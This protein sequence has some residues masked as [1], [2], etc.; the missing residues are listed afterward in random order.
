MHLDKVASPPQKRRKVDS[1]PQTAPHCAKM[2]ISVLTEDGNLFTLEIDSAET[3][4][5]VS[6]CSIP[7]PAALVVEF[8]FHNYIYEVFFVPGADFR[9]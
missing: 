6:L 8:V 3:V 9:R 7:R 4:R 1:D 2:K 5:C